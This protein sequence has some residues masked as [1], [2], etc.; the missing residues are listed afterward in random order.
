MYELC[1]GTGQRIGDCVAMEWAD[2]DGGYM[3]VVQDKTGTKMS[4][5]CPSRLQDYLARLPKTG[6][7]ILAKNLTEPIAKRAAQKAVE[8]VRR[9]LGIMGLVP[10]GWRYTAAVQLSDAGCSD[11][12]VQAVT[13][14]KTMDMV[15][16][17]RAKRDQRAASKRAQEK[18]NR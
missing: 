4:S 16:K 1:V 12:E 11:D 5:Y 10:H 9:S 3:A 7:H 2:F 13:G 17:Y 18:R 8:E 6:R 14:H 15:R